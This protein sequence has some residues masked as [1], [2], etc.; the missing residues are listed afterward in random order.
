MTLAEQG[1]G[2]LSPSEMASVVL[3]G[4]DVAIISWLG[5]HLV[6]EKKEFMYLAQFKHGDCMFLYL[7]IL[8]PFIVFLVFFYLTFEWIVSLTV[9]KTSKDRNMVF[10]I[11]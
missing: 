2:L 3:C 9:L 5:L 7:C 6:F 1:P 8:K 10:D 4:L 11:C